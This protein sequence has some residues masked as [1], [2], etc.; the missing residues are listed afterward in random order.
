MHQHNIH[1][2]SRLYEEEMCGILL[3]RNFIRWGSCRSNGVHL[4]CD[5][6]AAIGMSKG[7]KAVLKMTRS[8]TAYIS[9]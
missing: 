7:Y 3:Y 4:P 2:F 6:S 5:T 8:R 1:T 9:A